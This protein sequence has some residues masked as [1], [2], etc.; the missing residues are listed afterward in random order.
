MEGIRV[1]EITT[2]WAGP[3][4]GMMLA[5]MGAEVIKIENPK[6]PDVSRLT[7]PF[8]DGIRGIN[9]SGYFAVCNRGKKDCTL[10]LKTPEGVDILKRLVKVSDILV[11]NFPPRVM[12]SLGLGYSVLKEIK[13]DLIMISESGYGATGPDKECL[14]YGQVLEAYSGLSSLIGYPNRPPL[15]SLIPISDQTSATS[16]TVAVLAALHYRQIT[17]EGQHIDISELETL[18]NCFPDAIMEYT[19]NQRVPLP[20]GN[21]DEVMTPHGCYRCQG[22]DNWIAIA[23]NTD[24]E[25]KNLCQVIGKPGLADDERFQD[26]FLRWKNEDALNEI[27]IGWTKDKNHIEIFRQLQEA[28]VASGPVYNNEALFNDQH[29]RD[30]EFFAEIEHPEV[31]KRE[32]FG[33][34]AKLSETPGAVRRDPLLGEHNEWLLNE[35]LADVNIRQ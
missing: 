29:L 9:R 4:V 27:I 8:A 20:S 30:R 5:D 16:S 21:R 25:W 28:G 34:F 23:I 31:G 10:D 12:D 26:G 33:V 35:L 15:G 14:A 3:V 1:I 11:E 24:E 17:G 32:L 22:E 6:K 7:V 18:I 13:P 19:A 2:A